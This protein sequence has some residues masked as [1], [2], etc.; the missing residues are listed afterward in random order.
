[1]II[2]MKRKTVLF[3]SVIGYTRECDNLLP[4]CRET[5]TL[6]YFSDRF[7]CFPMS[8]SLHMYYD[9]CVCLLLISYIGG[10]LSLIR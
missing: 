8:T 3:S 5:S 2:N 1:M 10:L 7:T 9:N 6:S 4:V